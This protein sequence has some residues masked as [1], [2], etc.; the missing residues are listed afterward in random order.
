MTLSWA[1]TSFYFFDGSC[2]FVAG[3][4]PYGRSVSRGVSPKFLNE[5]RMVHGR[6]PA[7]LRLAVCGVS[8]PIPG[9]FEGVVYGY[10]EK[11]CLVRP[12]RAED[13]HHRI[14]GEYP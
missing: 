13:P 14:E 8:A 12:A 6:H 10:N 1:W 5:S 9:S 3:D 4:L 7:F 11:R 2:G